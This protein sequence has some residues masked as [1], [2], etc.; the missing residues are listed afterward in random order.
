MYLGVRMGGGIADSIGKPTDKDD[1][2][3]G[4]SIYGFLFFTIVSVILL[5]ITF[6]IIVDAFAKMRDRRTEIDF[7]VS[8]KCRICGLMR[9]DLE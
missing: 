9:S 7:D 5:N 4:V 8:N 1:E 2:Y 3:Y 6:A